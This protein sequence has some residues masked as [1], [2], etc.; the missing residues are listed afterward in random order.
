MTRVRPWI[1][2]LL[3]LAASPRLERWDRL[4]SCRLGS[5][6]GGRRPACPPPWLIGRPTTRWWTSLQEADTIDDAS[7]LYSYLRPSDGYPT[8]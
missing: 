8:L 5:G 2:V 4:D 3:A 6:N 1:P 7:H